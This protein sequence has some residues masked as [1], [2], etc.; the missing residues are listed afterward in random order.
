M[1]IMTAKKGKSEIQHLL[2][3]E[4][5]KKLLPKEIYSGNTDTYF[6]L[7]MG[8]KK[9]LAL[10]WEIACLRSGFLYPPFQVKLKLNHYNLEGL[11]MYMITFPENEYYADPVFA[12]VARHEQ[13]DNLYYYTLEK[14]QEMGTFGRFHLWGP[15]GI[16]QERIITCTEKGFIEAV[17]SFM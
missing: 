9:Y 5:V 2:L 14:T 11:S 3:N 17:R 1:D 12:A 7:S 16:E 13:S 6:N 10:L 15:E 8:Q 4:L